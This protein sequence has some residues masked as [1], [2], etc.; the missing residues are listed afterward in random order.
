MSAFKRKRGKQ[1]ANK[2]AKKVK[3]AAEGGEAPTEA[4]QEKTNEITIPPPVSLV[5][6]RACY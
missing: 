4:E 3:Y 1:A 2:K 6:A 5:S